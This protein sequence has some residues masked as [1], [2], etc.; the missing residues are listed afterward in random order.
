MAGGL[1]GGRTGTAAWH[2]EVFGPVLA[3]DS[4]L[5]CLA[6]CDNVRRDRGAVVA[7]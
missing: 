1:A 2:D 7:R 5:I 6:L 3:A 4:A